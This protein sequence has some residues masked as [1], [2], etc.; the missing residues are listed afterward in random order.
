MNKT[1][2]LVSIDLL[3]EREGMNI[4]KRYTVCQKI[5]IIKIRKVGQ[6]KGYDG[7]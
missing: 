2:N 7:D 6:G 4:F 1:K 3:G 5:S